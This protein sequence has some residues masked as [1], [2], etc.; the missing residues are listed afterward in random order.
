MQRDLQRILFLDIETAASAPDFESL[1]PRLQPLWVKKAGYLA[2]GDL[3][4]MDPSAIFPIKAGIF[5]E[6]GKVL[7][8][9]MGIIT[10]D[11]DQRP[12]IRIKSIY[13]KEEKRVLSDF[14]NL[15]NSHYPDPN[16]FCICGHNIREFDIPYLCRRMLIH[17]VKLP[18]LLDVGEKKPWELKHLVDT[19]D[20]WKFGDYKHYTSLNLLAALLGLPS[21]KDNMDGSM[22]NDEFWLNDAL[23]EIKDYCQMD[24]VTTIQVYLALSGMDFIPEHQIVYA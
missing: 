9:S 8:I 13:D 20:M 4:G 3:E 21:P 24:V 11:D 14:A 16:R 6:F 12:T 17:R 1:D 10:Y 23:E 5:A 18:L 2:R 7:C 19:L 22:V 15:L